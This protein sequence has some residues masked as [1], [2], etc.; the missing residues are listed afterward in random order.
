[1]SLQKKTL[2]ELRGIAQAMGIELKWD[3]GKEHLLQKINLHVAAKVQPP[4]RPIEIN[5]RQDSNNPTVTP[6]MLETAL[7]DFKPLG[8]QV[9]F[10]DAHTWELYCNQKRDSGSMYMPLWNIIQCARDVVKP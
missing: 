3:D 1:M 8:L 5:I 9:S 7:R 10:P 4:E 6:E 2:T